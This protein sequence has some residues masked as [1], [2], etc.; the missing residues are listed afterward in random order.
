MVTLF[1]AYRR[2]PAVRLKCLD[3]SR[4]KQEFK[5]D[6]D[7]NTILKRFGI[8][9]KL[10]SNVRMPMY[11]DF[12]DVNSFHQAVN[13][14][15]AA[16]ESFS[17]MPAHVRSRFQNDPERFVQFCLDDGNRAEA[18]K[19]GLV[20]DVPLKDG[21]Q[22]RVEAPSGAP[23]PAPGTTPSGSAAAAPAAS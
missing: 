19:L 1:S 10:P 15:A 2:P 13:A 12:S 18:V 20:P 11:G 22:G 5:E 3:P 16:N 7:I 8:T 4:A 21:P 14:I 6:S 17:A 23:A 9:G